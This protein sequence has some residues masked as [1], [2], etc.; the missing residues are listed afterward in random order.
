MTLFRRRPS[1]RHLLVLFLA[2]S[3]AIV[4]SP[5][6]WSGESGSLRVT[7]TDNNVVAVDSNG[8]RVFSLAALYGPDIVSDEPDVAGF[9]MKDV[10]KL[11]G[12]GTIFFPPA[13]KV[14]PTRN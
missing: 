11:F 6:R 3:S 7:I 13:V 1:L 12:D 10:K 9:L 4:A 8:K 5:L 14:R 2:A